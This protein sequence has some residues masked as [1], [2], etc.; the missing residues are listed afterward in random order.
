MEKLNIYLSVSKFVLSMVYLNGRQQLFTRLPAINKLSF[1]ND[2]GIQQEVSD[3]IKEKAYH[4]YHSSAQDAT[5]TAVS[6]KIQRKA[7]S[8]SHLQPHIA[9]Q[10]G[11]QQIAAGQFRRY[12]GCVTAL[13]ETEGMHS[14]FSGPERLCSFE[15]QSLS[16]L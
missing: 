5:R 3:K 11:K 13:T 15:S 8:D 2:T 14:L 12:Q 1:W 9:K 7:E 4:Q 6:L 16:L 10:Q